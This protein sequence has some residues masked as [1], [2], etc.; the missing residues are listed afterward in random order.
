MTRVKKNKPTDDVTHEMAFRAFLRSFGLLE[1]VMTPYFARFGISAAQWGVLRQLY[2]AEESGEIGL[3]V[4]ELS[5]RLLI[6]LPSATGVIDRLVKS[7]LVSRTAAANDLRAKEIALTDTGRKLVH[8]VLAVH[9]KQIESILAG[10]NQLEIGEFHF[11]LQKFQ[12]RLEKLADS[13]YQNTELDN[14]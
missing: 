14:G 5:N 10:L 13:E 7:G 2:R 4:T 3:R 12:T 9:D 1:R 8:R 11:L 6:R